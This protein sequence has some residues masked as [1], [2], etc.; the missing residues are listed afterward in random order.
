MLQVLA[1]D[2]QSLWDRILVAVIGPL[3][4]VLIGGL[5]VWGV[6]STVQRRREGADRKRDEDRAD[7]FRTED[8]RSTDDAVRQDLVGTMTEA[9]GLL[10]LM[11]QHCWR[12]K[13]DL[14]ADPND[15]P[16]RRPGRTAQTTG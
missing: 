11:T 2:N 7:L 15:A 13:Q 9:A 3:V 1:A 4:T 8:R 5:V 10:Y 16:G 14:K 6:T 12:A